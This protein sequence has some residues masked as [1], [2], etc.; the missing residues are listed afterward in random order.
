LLTPYPIN[1][2]P[3]RTGAK[4]DTGIAMSVV[5]DRFYI[6]GRN[7]RCQVAKTT[8]L[9]IKDILCVEIKTRVTKCLLRFNC[10]VRY[11]VRGFQREGGGGVLQEYRNIQHLSR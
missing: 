7:Y 3:Q 9:A 6:T 5:R 4:L 2:L 1:Y 8:R 10:V 11:Q